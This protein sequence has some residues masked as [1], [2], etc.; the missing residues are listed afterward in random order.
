MRCGV[1]M[2]RVTITAA[3]VRHCWL[4]GVGKAFTGPFLLNYSVFVFTFSL[5]LRFYAVRLIKL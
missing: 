2:L 1:E 4:G 3:P 5:F